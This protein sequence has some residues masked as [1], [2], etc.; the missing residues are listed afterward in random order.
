ML[1][2]YPRVSRIHATGSAATRGG[3]H[4]GT[5][6]HPVPAPTTGSGVAVDRGRRTVTVDGRPLSLTYLEFELLAHLVGHPQ[7][8]FTRRQL[9]TVVWGQTAYGDVRTVDVHIARLRRKLGPVHRDGIVTVRQVG[10]RFDPRAAAAG[11]G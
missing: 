6:H 7:Q 9:M 3:V 5:V 2:H 8:V 11:P 1:L 4:P 10:Y